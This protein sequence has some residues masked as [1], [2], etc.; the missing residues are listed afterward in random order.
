[1]RFMLELVMQSMFVAGF[2]RARF[3]LNLPSFRGFV[4]KSLTFAMINIVLIILH[5]NIVRGVVYFPLCNY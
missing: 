2:E 3:M 1:M 4:T 5:R